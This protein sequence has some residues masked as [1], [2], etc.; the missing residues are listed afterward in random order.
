MPT[1]TPEHFLL[2]LTRNTKARLKRFSRWRE[3]EGRPQASMNAIVTEALEMLL[4]RE[5]V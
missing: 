2:R 3:K 4:D 1:K 5:D